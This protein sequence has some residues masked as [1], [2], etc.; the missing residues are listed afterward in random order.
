MMYDEEAILGVECE[1]GCECVKILKK[2]IYNKNFNFFIF[3]LF[4]LF[5]LLNLKKIGMESQFFYKIRFKVQR[6]NKLIFCF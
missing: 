5:D 2:D 1:E 6:I 4:D 3:D